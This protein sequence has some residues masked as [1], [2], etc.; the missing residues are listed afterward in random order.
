MSI[1]EHSIRFILDEQVV[2]L[3]FGINGSFRPD[4]SLLNYLRHTGHT[5]VKE[6]CGEGDCGACTVV[7]AEMKGDK[8]KYKAINSCLVFLPMIHGCQVITAENLSLQQNGIM[9]L[10][11]VQKLFL[12]LNELTF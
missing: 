5:S 3:D 10:H 2:T 12:L 8:L 4:T 9:Y 1:P 11:P 7:I 6:G